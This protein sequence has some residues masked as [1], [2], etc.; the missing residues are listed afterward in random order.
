MYFVY[1]LKSKSNNQIYISSTNN[2]ERRL[3]QHN[4]GQEISTKR[5]MPWILYYYEAYVSES[6]AKTREKRLKNNG[7]AIRELKKRV[8]LLPNRS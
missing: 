2:L 5:Y 7:N 3:Q 4:N 6:L 8:G 1:I